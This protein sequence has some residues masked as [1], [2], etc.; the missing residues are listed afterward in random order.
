MIVSF[1]T[2]G[3]RPDMRRDRLLEHKL[4]GGAQQDAL[5]RGDAI[6]LNRGP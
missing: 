1:T 2:D 4:R 5:P 6:R 3:Q